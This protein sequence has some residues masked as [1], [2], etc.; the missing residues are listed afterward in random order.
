MAANKCGAPIQIV[1]AS[2]V[3]VVNVYGVA[4]AGAPLFTPTTTG[5]MVATV[6][7]ANGTPVILVNADG[8]QWVA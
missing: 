2:G 6:V 8:T 7:A 5:G 3:P 4:A 1:A